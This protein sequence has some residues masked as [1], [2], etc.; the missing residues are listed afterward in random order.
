MSKN[1]TPVVSHIS[2]TK[3]FQ[4]MGQKGCVIWLTGLSGS[5]KSTIGSLLEAHLFEAGFKV[6]M[7]DGDNLRSG[8]NKDLGFSEEDREENIRR[9]GEVS[10]LL[11]DAGIIVISAF[12]SPFSVDREKAKRSIGADR[13]VEVFVDCPVS[14]CEQRDVKGLYKK[15]REGA[16]KNFT[17]IDSEYE[18]PENPDV[19]LHTDKE[20]AIES[21]RYLAD[22]VQDKITL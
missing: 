6:F 21:L 2:E 13:F 14:V 10:K 22:F 12:I 15:V 4:L 3:R 1:I 9:V 16:I 18:P 7:L 19:V 8:L 5:G 11:S 20:S 17:G